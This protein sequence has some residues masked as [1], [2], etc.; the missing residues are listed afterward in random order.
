LTT[1]ISGL[2]E[3]KAEKFIW[4]FR[5]KWNVVIF[6]CG[7]DALEGPLEVLFCTAQKEQNVFF[8]LKGAHIKIKFKY[9]LQKK[10]IQTFLD[11]FM[12]LFCHHNR[13]YLTKS[14]IF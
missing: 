6:S 4:T 11:C 7:A 8:F 12:T 3:Q 13:H 5:Q 10:I 14:S 1:I 2:A 9:V